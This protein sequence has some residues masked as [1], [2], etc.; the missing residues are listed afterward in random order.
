MNGGESPTASGG[1][2]GVLGFGLLVSSRARLEDN[3]MYSHRSPCIVAISAS[4]RCS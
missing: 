1:A 4:P 2:A 3:E